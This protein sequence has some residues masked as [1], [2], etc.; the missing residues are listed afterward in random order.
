M[1]TGQITA[2]IHFYLHVF[3][4]KF[5]II[6]NLLRHLVGGRDL[7]NR[8]AI[9]IGIKNNGWGMENSQLSVCKFEEDNEE[10]IMRRKC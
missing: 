2:K 6:E 3:R 8:A 7:L 10:D 5:I 4:Q 9:W 1:A